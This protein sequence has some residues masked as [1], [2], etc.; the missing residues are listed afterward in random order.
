MKHSII[1]ICVTMG[2]LSWVPRVLAQDSALIEP[3]QTLPYT[4]CIDPASS[5][6]SVSVTSAVYHGSGFHNHDYGGHSSYTS[7]P[8]GADAGG[9]TGSDGCMDAQ[10]WVG[11]AALGEHLVAGQHRITAFVSGAFNQPYLEI[12]V[13]ENNPQWLQWLPDHP[14]YQKVGVTSDHQTPF[15]GTFN[16]VF[17][18]QQISSEFRSQTGLIP[19]INDMSLPWG[20]RFDLG[21]NYGGTWWRSPHGEHMRGLNADIPFSCLGSHRDRYAE[22]AANHGGNPEGHPLPPATPNHWHLRFQY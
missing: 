22:I 9:Y 21:P 18:V 13:A 7:R 8:T 15:Y 4:V 5:G 2:A 14:D 17:Q 1:A 12:T 10:W 11:S 20:G 3:G 19:C 16:A 6:N